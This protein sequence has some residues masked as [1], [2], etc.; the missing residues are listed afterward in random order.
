[1]PLRFREIVAATWSSLSSLDG[2]VLGTIRGLLTGPGHVARAWIDG[3]RTR[4]LHPVKFL[5][6]VSLIIALSYE[7]LLAARRAMQVTGA[8]IYTVGL[9]AY[10]PM[11]S[12]FGLVL[13][14]VIALG[15]TAIGRPFRLRLPWLDWY[16]LGA[17]ATGMGALLQLTF[18]LISLPLPPGWGGWLAMAEFAL[19]LALLVWG[20]YHLVA[21]NRRWQAVLVALL[22]PTLGWL[23]IVAIET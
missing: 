8:A 12:L 3:K 23:V 9:E 21:R 4:Y 6:V 2:P 16:V 5:F 13:P 14:V 11:F 19:P 17:Y 22:T 15:I 18:K 20:S 10:S 1:M 7:P